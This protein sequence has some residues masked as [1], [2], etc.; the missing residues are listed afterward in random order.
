MCVSEDAG[1]SARG[2]GTVAAAVAV[3]VV[4]AGVMCSSEQPIDISASLNESRPPG[5]GRLM[6]RFALGR[7]WPKTG[8]F[9]AAGQGAQR[10]MEVVVTMAVA[11]LWGPQVSYCARLQ[12]TGGCVHGWSDCYGGDGVLRDSEEGA[13]E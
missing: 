13:A 1:R 8:H 7:G 11:V 9:R 12:V 6:V 10:V 5:R 4:T 3:M 2:G